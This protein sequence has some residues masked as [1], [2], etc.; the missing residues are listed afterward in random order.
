M[1]RLIGT[2]GLFLGLVPF[3]RQFIL[4]T[5]ETSK[6]FQ[7][8][9]KS[10]GIVAEYVDGPLGLELSNAGKVTR[11]SDNLLHIEAFLQP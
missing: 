11:S 3:M 1:A 8:L 4:K 7:R 9:V 5:I 2:R 6:L 10:Y